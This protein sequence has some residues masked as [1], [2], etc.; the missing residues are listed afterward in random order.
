MSAKNIAVAGTGYVGLVTGVCLAH[1]GHS[2]TCVDVDA[3]KIERL[4]AGQSPI[5]EP[6]L[7]ELLQEGIGAGRLHF[8]TD[9]AAAYQNAE[10]IFIGVG[11]P[12]RPD[13]S[14]NLD[15]VFAVVREIASAARRDCVVVV[16]S[17][18]PIGT[19]DEVERYLKEHQTAPVK[20]DVAS[21]PEFLAQG[22]AVRDTLHASRIVIG[23]EAER[24]RRVLEEVYAD[25]DAPRLFTGRR[26]AEMIKYAS[27]DFLALKISYINEIANLCEQV[28]ANIDDVAAG[29]GFDKRIGR[30]FLRAGIGYGG[31]CFPK[32][33]K[34]LDSFATIRGIALKTVAATIQ[35]NE[36]QKRRLLQKAH[37]H[38]KSLAGVT[39]AVLGLAFKPGTDDL[40]EAPSLLCVPQL[41]AEGAL[42]RAW[43]PVAA[44]NFARRLAAMQTA[45]AAQCSAKNA[46]APQ[47]AQSGAKNTAGASVSGQ[48]GENAGNA[49]AL[50]TAAGSITYCRSIPEA[51]SGAGLCLILTEWPEVCALRPA[52]FAEAMQTPIVLDGRNCF[53]P[54][55]LRQSGAKLRYESIGRP[56]VDT[57]EG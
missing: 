23:T 57:R 47:T 54:E 17:T 33:T 11:T 25:F 30:H 12:E 36:A 37:A 34:A 41:L 39:V 28:G 50:K 40:R 9:G 56:P 3:A 5:Y 24:P 35:V 49:A 13:G 15:Y 8:T 26:S 20:L 21:N 2:V 27:N 46:A 43:D 29:M 52:L 16:K 6:G 44:A 53:A 1:H 10:V 22:T 55:A 4:C 42:V 51:L 48:A 45:D 31:S 18:V 7:T 38:Y 19:N 14:A 32:D